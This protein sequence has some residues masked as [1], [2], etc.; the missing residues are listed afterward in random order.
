MTT[1]RPARTPQPPY[2]AVVF[3]SVRAEGDRG[4]AAM[5]ERLSELVTDQP[6]F[7]GVDSVRGADGFGITVAYFDTEENLKAWRNQAEHTEARN[8]GRKAWYEELSVHVARV[9]RAYRWERT[10]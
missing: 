7:L 2:Y 3:T 8:L 5:S 10:E 9:E 1:Q 6:G 4:Y